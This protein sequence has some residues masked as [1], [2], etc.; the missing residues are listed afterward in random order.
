MRWLSGLNFKNKFW[1]F[2]VVFSPW[3]GKPSS[4]DGQSYR[5]DDLP[6]GQW[7][8]NV[9]IPYWQI[10]SFMKSKWSRMTVLLIGWSSALASEASSPRAWNRQFPIYTNATPF[11]S[12]SRTLASQLDNGCEPNRHT[13]RLQFS[14]PNFSSS[15]EDKQALLVNGQ[16]SCTTTIF[17]QDRFRRLERT[18]EGIKWFWQKLRSIPGPWM[19]QK[20]EFVTP[21]YTTWFA[22]A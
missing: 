11:V 12:A 13:N 2:V 6:I 22:L 15:V 3:E 16:S 17:G 18:E 8:A 21:W 9:K 5:P 7:Q 10:I 1:A 4:A 20:P 14:R 19:A